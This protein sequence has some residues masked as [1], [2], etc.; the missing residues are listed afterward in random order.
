MFLSLSVV[1]SFVSP[2]STRVRLEKRHVLLLICY[3]VETNS[4]TDSEKPEGS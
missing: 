1:V 2:E 4:E 3:V